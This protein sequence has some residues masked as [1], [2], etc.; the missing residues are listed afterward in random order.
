MRF[1]SH[2]RVAALAL[3][4]AASLAHADCPY[5]HFLVGQDMGTLFLD[6]SLLYRHWNQDWGSN[7]NPQGQ[8]YYEFMEM[9]GGGWIRVEP[10]ISELADPAYQLSGTQGQDYNLVLERV[11]ATAGLQFFDDYMQP[12]MTSNGAG[13]IL[14]DYANHHVH[15]RYYLPDGMDPT[16][17]YTVSYRLTDSTGTYA[18]SEVYTFHLGAAGEP[19]TPGDANGDGVVDAADYIILKRNMG[20]SANSGP[21]YGDFNYFG[22]TDWNDLQILIGAMGGGAGGTPTA[23]TP[24]PTTLGLLAIGAMAIIRRTKDLNGSKKRYFSSMSGGAS[25]VR[26]RTIEQGRDAD[27]VRA[28]PSSPAPRREAMTKTGRSCWPG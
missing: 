25:G 5:D 7:P 14:S 24:E 22:A 19:D 4:L 6:T 10:G 17:A 13:L 26:P 28:C 27:A 18:N 15:M 8:Q 9:Y 11:Y 16:S 1:G 23:M 3:S 21:S 2:A 12:V 20:Q